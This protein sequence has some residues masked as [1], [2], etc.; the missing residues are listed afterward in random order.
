MRFSKKPKNKALSCEPDYR[1]LPELRRGF[2][3]GDGALR[4]PEPVVSPTDDLA[5][6]AASPIGEGSLSFA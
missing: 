6:R 5:V 2:C 4:R 1:N 3:V